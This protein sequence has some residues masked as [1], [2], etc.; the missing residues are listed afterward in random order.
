VVHAHEAATEVVLPDHAGVTGYTLIW[1]SAGEEPVEDPTEHAP[2]TRIPVPA[3][4]MHLFRAHGEQPGDAL[5][6]D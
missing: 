4:S 2:G 1:D 5:A 3:L 6:D